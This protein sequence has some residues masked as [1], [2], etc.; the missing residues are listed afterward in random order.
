LQRALFIVTIFLN[1][2]LLF[3]VQP[4]VARIILPVFG[5]SP[6]VWTAS[7]VFFQACL[8][9][10]YGYA[11]LTTTRLAAKQQAWLHVVV[12]GVAFLTLPFGLPAW[13]GA[14]GTSN[15]TP[16]VLATLA[17]MVGAS[18]FAISA[19][20]P[21]IQR[22]FSV[23]R[24]KD[25]AD[26]Y[27]LYS[28]SN[29]GSLLA[30]LAYPILLEPVFRL[31]EQSAI[32]RWAYLGLVILMAGCAVLTRRTGPQVEGAQAPAQP[33]LWRQRLLWVALTA[34]PTSLL[35]GLTAFLTTNIAPIPLLWVVPLSLYLMTYILAFAKKPLLSAKVLGRAA[36][37]IATPLVLVIMLESDQPL[38]PI[39]L[40]H[41]GTFFLLAWMCH[42]RLVEDRPAT[43]HLTEF[44]LWISVGGVIGG[45]VNG[46]V[47]P[48][49]FNNLY[50]YPLAIVAAL[51][52]RPRIAETAPKTWAKALPVATLLLATTAILIAKSSGLSSGPL[53]TVMTIGIPLVIT[54]FAMDWPV[55]AGLAV[56]SVVLS[57]LVF[58]VST[59]QE[60]VLTRRSFFGVHKVLKSADGRFYRLVHGNT[61]HGIQDKQDPK[62]PLTYYHP[63]G[64]IGH[65]IESLTHLK[66]IGLVGLGV[67][68]LAAYGK[69]GQHMTFFEI[70]PEVQRIATNPELFTFTRDSKAKVDFVLGDARLT[71]AKEPD[72]SFDL[73][74]LDAFSSDA[75]PIHLLTIEA[76]KTYLAKLRPGGVL[77]VHISN[78]YLDLQPVLKAVTR[79]LKLQG[80]IFEDGAS[81][82]EKEF[83]KTSSIWIALARTEADLAPLLN[84]RNWGELYE[85]PVKT[86][87]DDYSNVL[88][89]FH[90]DM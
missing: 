30:L 66:D 55:L 58:K 34:V 47:A 10:G 14:V 42:R 35:L 76:F 46:I 24:D 60:I 11:H 22:W 29:I 12:L 79:D 7:M 54:M 57:G 89:V 71:L 90:L 37:L 15:P 43:G 17:A 84:D 9:L 69:P 63:T 36:P 74:V 45:L 72:Q 51:M 81:E 18:F 21:L 75:I 88:R 61:I 49:L 48:L 65:A 41:L 1:S 56:G 23:S 62:T 8:L 28:A 78:R 67:G 26:P 77:A 31:G 20:A 68:S 38:I 83:G 44:Y 70:D 5:G 80:A 40:F 86:W 59:D 13:S 85:P 73:L 32:W 6:A 52:L 4:L 87:T 64:P 82:S 19:G 53:R 2:A 50:E 27:F 3:L 33:L 39:A 16:A 25:A